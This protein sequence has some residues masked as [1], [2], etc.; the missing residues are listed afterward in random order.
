MQPQ[1][2]DELVALE[3][4]QEVYHDMNQPFEAPSPVVPGPYYA[5]CEEVMPEIGNDQDQLNRKVSTSKKDDASLSVDRRDF[6]K[7]FG[8]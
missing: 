4:T 8:L 3:K 6:M 7:L 1:D 2:H 5:S